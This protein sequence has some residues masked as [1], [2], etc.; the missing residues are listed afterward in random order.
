[1]SAEHKEPV[2]RF[3]VNNPYVVCDII[4][5]EAV[6]VNLNLGYYYSLRGAGVDI[7]ESFAGGCSLEEAVRR[8]QGR[9]TGSPEE[10][11]RSVGDLFERFKEEGFLIPLP[12]GEAGAALPSRGLP[13]GGG[14]TRPVFVPPNLEKFTDMEDILLLDPIHDVDE[15]GWPNRPSQPA[16]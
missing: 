15:K 3:K 10:I 2:V 8:I 5:G 1:V 7:W 4:E 9:Y 16:K 13:E 12:E 14:G 6:I 11:K